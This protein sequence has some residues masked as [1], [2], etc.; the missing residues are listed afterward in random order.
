MPMNNRMT[1]LLNKIERRLGTKMLNLPQEIC[2]DTWAHEVIEG[3]TLDTFSRYF[4]HKMIYILNKGNKKNG[5][6]IIDE[7]ICKSVEILGAGDI[8]WHEFSSKSPAYQYGGGFGTFDMLSTS[9]DAEDIMMTQMIADHTSLFAN[10]IY[11]SYIP[12]NRVKLNAIIQNDIIDFMQTIPI[13]LFV[14]HPTNLM[15]IA[16]T[17][18]ELFEKLAIVDVAAYLFNE[19]KYYDGVDTVFASTDLKL[20]DLENK[21]NTRD[22]I[23]E[24]LNE[25]YVSAANFNQPVMMTI[26]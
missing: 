23:V 8:D 24:K 20:S 3:D 15:T 11:V 12:P 14:K 22:E 2:K 25:S 21:A 9:Y 18:M 13:N 4:P 26:N 19:L 6:Y 1:R 16:P 7:D 17:K 5:Y 10:G